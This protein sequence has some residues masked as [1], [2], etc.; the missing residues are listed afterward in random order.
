MTWESSNISLLV[1][2]KQDLKST[3][4]QRQQQ[5]QQQQQNDVDWLILQ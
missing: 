5:Q 3:F 1:L 2:E 4:G